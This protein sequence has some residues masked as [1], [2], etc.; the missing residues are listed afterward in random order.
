VLDVVRAP[1]VSRSPALPCLT[2]SFHLRRHCC[3]LHGAQ[4]GASRDLGSEV[5]IWLIT[6]L[7]SGA[8]I[9]FESSAKSD[10]SC[11]VRIIPHLL[12]WLPRGATNV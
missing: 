8:K 9:A 7:R 5:A 6:R 3:A 4:M 10:K 1:R 2:A 11:R 12:G